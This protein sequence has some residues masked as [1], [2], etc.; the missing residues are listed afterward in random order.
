MLPSGHL[1]EGMRGKSGGKPGFRE[2]VMAPPL[3]IEFPEAVYHVTARWSG[4][5]AILR[6][7]EGRSAFLEITERT[8]ALRGRRCL[9]HC[10][11]GISCRVSLATPEP[12]CSRSM[13]RRK[14]EYSQAFNGLGQREIAQHLGPPHLQQARR[15]ARRR[16]V[17]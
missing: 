3:R 17:S 12:N 15:P 10:L 8:V 9:P 7:D 2:A 11:M 16:R 13:R 4:R 5:G 14:G 1:A 6:S